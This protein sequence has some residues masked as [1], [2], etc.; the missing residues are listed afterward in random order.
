MPATCGG[1]ILA[2]LALNVSFAVLTDRPFKSTP[3]TPAGEFD[4]QPL[5]HSRIVA[6][7]AVLEQILFKESV[8]RIEDQ[9]LRPRLVLLE[10]IG[11]E[12][13]ALVGA[14][15][16]AKR[17]WR[18]SDHK[19]A[20]ILHCFELSA[21][22]LRL[23]PGVPGVRHGLGRGLVIAVDGAELEGD[24]WRDDEAVIGQCRAA[25]EPDDL[26][27]RINPRGGL[28]DDV[29]AVALR[30]RLVT[31]GERFERPKT[32]KIKVAEKA[33][34]IT[35]LRLDQRDIESLGARSQIFRDGRAPNAAADHDHPRLCLAKRHSRSK[36]QAGGPSGGAEF[37]TCPAFHCG[38]ASSRCAAR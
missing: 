24:A 11:D 17:V 12:A 33:G 1:M 28:M 32:G 26:G 38:F 16:T 5:D 3:V 36:C 34:R 35:R 22:Q 20:P 19:D 6:V 15:R 27:C 31:V 25:L 13:S 18:G 23:G 14:G 29:D 2:T 37:A 9:D 10:I 4:R 30:K 8:L 7:P 21:Q